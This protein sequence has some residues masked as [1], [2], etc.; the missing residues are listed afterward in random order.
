MENIKNTLASS[1]KKEPYIFI[2]YAHKDSARVLPIIERLSGLGFRVWYDAGIE[3]G[4]EWP[5]YIA[6]RL[7][8]SACV[9][10]FLSAASVDSF[11]CRQ[12]INYAI[13]LEKPTMTVYL[14]EL[15]LTG[16]MRMRL[17]LSQAMFYHRHK[18]LDSFIKEL[19]RSEMIEPCMNNEKNDKEKYAGSF[20]KQPEI[21]EN[22]AELNQ[23]EGAFLIQN[24]MLL[25]YKGKDREVT[26]PE[27]V[28]VIGHAAFISQSITKV[29]IPNTVR[30]IGDAAFQMCTELTSLTI[31][32]SVKKLG[33]AICLGCDKLSSVTL[34]EGIEAIGNNMFSV[35]GAL[36]SVVIPPSVKSVEPFAF[37]ACANLESV[38]FYPGLE[39]IA[40]D[41]FANCQL[42]QTVAIPETVTEIGARA[43]ENCYNLKKAYVSKKTKY[44]RFFSKSFPR[45]TWVIK[46]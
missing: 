14:E 28:T 18:S 37:A 23:S 19:A 33:T 25:E 9:I 11:N 5:E 3:A 12:E 21:A 31:P 41:S 13:D 20:D 39:L 17:G 8:N 10:A 22:I 30:E 26:V 7:E 29:I 42:L 4:T 45:N 43:F 36:K 32:G 6:K 1:G 44:N 46:N 35:C 40:S 16:G 2:S 15:K 38:T 34:E 24:G 27:G